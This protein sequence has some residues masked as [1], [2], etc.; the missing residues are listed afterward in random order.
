MKLPNLKPLDGFYV[1]FFLLNHWGITLYGSRTTYARLPIDLA[2]VPLVT[3]FAD[4]TS[5]LVQHD[6][7]CVLNCGPRLEW[8]PGLSLYDINC[9][10]FS[11]R[12][13][14]QGA[15]R[16]AEFATYRG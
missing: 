11:A 3:Q 1:Y 15:W 9:D 6:E 8:V 2:D 13:W 10:I 14:H 4:G 12:I 5:I 16:Q 7:I